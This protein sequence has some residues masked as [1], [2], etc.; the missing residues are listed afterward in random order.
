MTG[1]IGGPLCQSWSETGSLKGIEDVR[2]Q[3]FYEYIRILRDTNL[4]SLLQRMCRVCLQKDTQLLLVDLLSC[5]QR[6]FYFALIFPSL[7]LA[8]SSVCGLLVA[9]KFSKMAN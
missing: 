7:F 4:F 9:C 6:S 3:L 1:I 2:G 8:S 5:L